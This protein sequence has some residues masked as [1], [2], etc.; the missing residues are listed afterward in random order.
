MKNRNSHSETKQNKKTTMATACTKT[1][2]YNHMA[3][4]ITAVLQQNILISI[5]NQITIDLKVKSKA[6]ARCKADFMLPQSAWNFLI[7]AGRTQHNI[8]VTINTSGATSILVG[9]KISISP[10]PE[11]CVIT[12]FT[13][14]PVRKHL[15]IQGRWNAVVM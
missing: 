13:K 15:Q 12:D 14:E 4:I 9:R 11:V 6:K 2:T 3:S 1:G 7:S 10:Q 8:R 5:L